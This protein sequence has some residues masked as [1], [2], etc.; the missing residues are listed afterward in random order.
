MTR[1][2][3]ATVVRT[4][5]VPAVALVLSACGGGGDKSRPGGGGNPPPVGSCNEATEFCGEIPGTADPCVEDQYWP[6][7][8]ASNLRPLQVHYSQQVSEAKA[9]E[10]ITLLEESWTIQVENLGF[11]A[12][13]SDLGAC[14][15]DGDFDVFIWPGIDGAFVSSISG[16]P[17]TPYNDVTSY[18]AFDPVGI[19]GGEFLNSFMAHE[20]NHAVQASDDWG[21]DALHYEAGATF[22]ETLVYPDDQD[23][24]FEIEDFQDNPHWSLFYDDFGATWYTYAAAM[25][26]HYL[27]ERYFQGDPGFYAR[28]WR[29]T[30]SDVGADR[31]DYFDA[32]RFVLLNERGVTLDS[33][34]VEFMQWRWFVAEN[35]DGAHFDKG[36]EW[37][38]T[39]AVDELDAAT[40]PVSHPL[41]AMVYGANYVVVT[42]S[43]N[44]TVRFSAAVTSTDGDVAWRLLDVSTGDVVA[45]VIL[46]AGEEIA[47]VA[48]V[49]PTQEIWS[50]NISFDEKQAELALAI[51]P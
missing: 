19:N 32:L 12:P 24:F 50:G 13:V 9:L 10:M 17:A 34:V 20:F 22:A 27:H 7:S 21:E 23:W 6:L 2:A 30:R 29:A 1:K 43:S 3:P 42:N 11:T 16:I 47:L 28:I 33:T 51:V 41:S 49:L 25:Y 26:L 18:M 40:L 14:G 48:V 45:P 44:D 36:A 8:S 5:A 46:E 4:L 15:P 39:V 35:D 38:F 31:P 37:P